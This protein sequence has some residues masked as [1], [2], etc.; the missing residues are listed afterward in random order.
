MQGWVRIASFD[1]IP[2]GRG[3]PATVGDVE[4]AVFRHGEE[5]FAIGRRCSHQGAPLE[6][7]RL[8][9]TGSVRTVTCPAHGSM[10]DLESGRVRRAPATRPLP[11][12]EARVVD[13]HVEVRPRADA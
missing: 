2:D 13:G 12:Y 9:F 6:R 1:D 11:V 8:T 3:V 10:F 7:G 5:V 4:V